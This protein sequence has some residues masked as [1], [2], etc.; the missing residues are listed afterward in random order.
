MSTGPFRI[1]IQEAMKTLRVVLDENETG[2]S[3]NLVWIPRTAHFAED[4]QILTPQQIGR[5]DD[6]DSHEPVRV[7]A[8][9]TSASQQD[10]H[11]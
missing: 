3:A 11:D 7:L 4:H 10:N 2:I 9:R 8:R 6:V 5:V 1:E